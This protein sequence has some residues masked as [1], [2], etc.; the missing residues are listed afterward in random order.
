[1]PMI[2]KFLALLFLARD[3]THRQHWATDSYAQHQALGVF[4]DAIV[5]LADKLAEA[6]MGRTGKRITNMPLLENEY[7]GEID[8]VLR[9]QLAWLE[10]NRY[11][12]A[13]K[14]DSTLQN[15]IDEIVAQYLSTLYQLTLE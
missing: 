6:H 10:S 2:N 11:A 13:K 15:I 4:Y 5:D 12:V 9:Q 1:M 7:G 14:D 3:L 8:E